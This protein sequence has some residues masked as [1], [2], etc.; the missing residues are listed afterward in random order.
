VPESTETWDGPWT[1]GYDPRWSGPLSAQYTFNGIVDELAAWNRSLSFT[2]MTNLY[3]SA[4]TSGAGC[5][6]PTAAVSGS[7]TI[8]NGGSTMISAALTGAGPWNVTW[9][10]A[11]V[12]SGVATSPATRNVSPST[13]TNYTVTALSDSA[14]T[15]QAGNLT[16][17]AV[18]T[19]NARPTSAASGSA[20]I[21]NGGST[22]ISA[23]LSGTGPWNVSWSDGSNQNAV[24]TSPATRSVNPSTTT[25]YTVTNLTD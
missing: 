2:E 5:T 25:I 21:C 17:S 16:G 15:A 22:N 4:F 1:A 19:V 7:A 18:V 8:C 10:D 9:S 6:P 3:A 12:Q 14:C 23:A 20:T 13:T 24:A 11:V